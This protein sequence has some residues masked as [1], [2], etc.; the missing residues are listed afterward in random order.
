MHFFADGDSTV[1]TPLA[2]FPTH[3][4]RL[5]FKPDFAGHLLAH[6]I[7][8]PVSNKCSSSYCSLR[9]VSNVSG[10]N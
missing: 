5:P 10:F 7:N 4:Y 1:D 3:I 6:L 8:D 2:E 9:L